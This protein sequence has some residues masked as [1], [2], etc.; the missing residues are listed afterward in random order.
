MDGTL[1]GDTPYARTAKD[2]IFSKLRDAGG[3]PP[4]QASEEGQQSC[5]SSLFQRMASSSLQYEY[6]DWLEAQEAEDISNGPI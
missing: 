1:L 2:I 3:L 6:D 5:L 4:R